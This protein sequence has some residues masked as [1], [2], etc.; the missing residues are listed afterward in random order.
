MIGIT[1]QALSTLAENIGY[2]KLLAVL[3]VSAYGS[4]HI[5]N[6][7][8]RHLID[9]I[10]Y[11]PASGSKLFNAINNMII[12]HID[13]SERV[14]N[15]AHIEASK[16]KWPLG[17]NVLVVDDSEINLEIV[18]Q[19]L[20][21]NGVTVTALSCGQAALEQLRL[22]PDM[23]DIVL[24]DVQMP[25]MD[26]LETTTLIRQQLGLA[27]LPIVALTASTSAQEKKRALDVGMNDFLTKPI[28]PSL[29]ISTLRRLVGGYRGRV[30]NVESPPSN[31][32]IM[33]DKWPIILGIKENASLLGGDLILFANTLERL[34]TE[35]QNLE[36]YSEI[37]ITSTANAE[38]I[39]SVDSTIDR[40]VLAG[41]V[42]KLRGSAGLIG[43]QQL[44]QLAG[45]AETALRSDQSKVD[46][47]LAQIAQCLIK[48]RLDSADFLSQQQNMIPKHV[49]IA[50]QNAPS[51]NL[52]KMKILINALEKQELS[53]LSIVEKYSKSLRA[54]LTEK[55]FRE[56]EVMLKNLNFKQALVLLKSND[57]IF[58]E[59]HQ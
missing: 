29:L 30:I 11:K 2:K 49:A 14:S 26:G 8:K 12:K 44:Y 32:D 20:I 36:C 47:L 34:L 24:M 57:W 37:A 39:K 5:A 42:H 55:I 7:D 51:M 43:A 17:I 3:V 48:L 35:F 58:E 54:I 16:A 9:K 6:P 25:E 19:I 38:K 23:F 15:S 13:G 53:A 22:T 18:G 31:N 52:E 28:E 27:S 56:F 41:Q 59:T 1:L 4:G 46:L 50:V 21:R 40:L 45:K 33:I 10:L